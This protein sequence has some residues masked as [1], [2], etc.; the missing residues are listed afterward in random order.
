L[1]FAEN[2][3]ARL[4]VVYDLIFSYVIKW[5]RQWLDAFDW[6]IS[7]DDSLTFGTVVV[8]VMLQRSHWR[9]IR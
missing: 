9:V 1:C 7:L 8:W 5:D 3:G 2:D 6:M 4:F